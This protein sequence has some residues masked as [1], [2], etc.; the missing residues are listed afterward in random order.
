[1]AWCEFRWKLCL[2]NYFPQSFFDHWFADLLGTQIWRY[3]RVIGIDYRVNEVDPYPGSFFGWCEDWTADFE[4]LADDTPTPCQCLSQFDVE[5]VGADLSYWAAY[6]RPF[7]WVDDFY[8][9]KFK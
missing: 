6:G 1:M 5:G 7:L 3:D 9:Y 4:V 8:N 2:Q